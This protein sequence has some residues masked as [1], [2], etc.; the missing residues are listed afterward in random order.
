MSPKVRSRRR[1]SFR[2]PPDRLAQQ[3][4]NTMPKIQNDPL[5]VLA[6][7]LLT[8]MLI[9]IIIGMV[10]LGI[11]FTAVI[12]LHGMVAEKLAKAGAAESTYWLILVIFPLIAAMLAAMHRFVSTLRAI[13]G[14]V[15]EGDPFS[16]VNAERLRAMAWLSVIVQVLTLP[17]DFLSTKVEEAAKGITSMNI[18]AE[19]STNGLLLAL[20][21]FILARVFRTGAQMREELEGTV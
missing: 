3:E 19:F 10:G 13:V 15:E 12:G 11:G 8:F 14:T 5:L 17:V 20:V 18:D 16:P 7:G 4:G 2:W 6:K 21:L 1:T 9:F